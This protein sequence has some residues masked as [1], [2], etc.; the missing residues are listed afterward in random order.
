MWDEE[1]LLFD[2]GEG[3]Q[4]QMLFAGVTAS[5]ITRICITHFHGDHCLGVPGVLARMSLD[6]VPHAVDVCYPAQ[7]HEVFT[8]LRHAALYRDAVGLRERPA[9][10]PGPVLRAAAF[11][12][13]ARP[14]SHTVPA[15]GYL[16]VEADVR[17]MLPDRLAAV[18][19][20]GPDIGRPQREGRLVTAWMTWP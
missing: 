15:V 5:R 3:T 8:R 7:D 16:L 12:V 14:L 20:V 9:E 17:R 13:E 6:R 10:T 19:V 4:R 2:P 1:G 18:G 11:G